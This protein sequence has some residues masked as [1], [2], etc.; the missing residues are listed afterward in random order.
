[1]DGLLVVDKPAGPTSHDVVARVR[2][3]LRER[4]VGHTGTLDPA[5]TGVLPLVVGRATRLAQF[6]SGSDKSYEAVIRFGF[7]TDTG[8]AQGRAL[9]VQRGIACPSRDAIDAALD[10]FRGEFLQQPPA[11]SAKKIDGKRSHKLARARARDD[12]RLKPS[13]SGTISPDPPSLA[14]ASPSFGAAGPRELPDPPDPPDLP[15]P[16]RVTTYA[17]DVVSTDGDTVTLRVDCSAGFYIRSLAHDVGERLGVG[18]HL[19][20]LR[21]T[22]SGTLTLADAV[23][24]AAIEREPDLAAG[25]VIA[26]AKMLPGLAPVVLTSDG[27]RKAIHGRELGPGD[28]VSGFANR[29]SGLARPSESRTATPESRLYRLL[30]PAGQLVAI[31]RPAT[32]SGLLHPS[33]VLV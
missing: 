18:G 24:L 26:L 23:G 2:R 9:G 12:A 3:A 8:D 15:D 7:S 25:R 14:A 21:R 31:A 29:D 30:D 5:A 19:V 28:C 20:A 11:F 32:A 4:R 16:V 10:A 17:I 33:V 13:R 6:L 22:R 1:M 27:V